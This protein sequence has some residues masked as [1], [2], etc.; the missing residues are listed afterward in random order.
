MDV[1]G[2]FHFQ[3]EDGDSY[4]FPSD[5]VKAFRAKAF[6]SKPDLAERISLAFV[7]S[8]LAH[9]SRYELGA[10]IAQAVIDLEAGASSTGTKPA[11]AFRRA[12]LIG[13]WHAHFTDAR[14]LAANYLLA[15]PHKERRQRFDDAL[16]QTE[17]MSVDDRA[18]EMV[19]RV[20]AQPL[21]DR[22]AQGKATGEWIVYLPRN[23]KNYYLAATNHRYTWEGQQNLLD[24]IMATCSVDFPEL[25]AWIDEAARLQSIPA[26]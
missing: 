15:L 2:I 13:L 3:F 20:W 1:S 17:G 8:M 25:G 24:G 23:G 18:R 16:K 4:A 22:F 11:S 14:F 26:S 10:A 12:P 9:E 19:S 21:D 7:V 6:G 5:F